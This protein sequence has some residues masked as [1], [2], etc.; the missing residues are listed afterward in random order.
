MQTTPLSLNDMAGV[1]EAI[2]ELISKYPELPFKANAQTITWQGLGL[3]EGIGIITLSGAVYLKKYVSGSF[4]GQMPFRIE[5]QS[6]PTTNKARIK[7]Q[8]FLE[9]LAYWMETCGIQFDEEIELQQIERTTPV[10]K[11]R[12]YEDGS[13]VYS[14]TMNIQ[15]YKRK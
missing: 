7:A 13:E 9:S 1:S 11:N 15:Y 5:Y 12:V 6:K 14:C 3:G 2:V 8:R 4:V 10:I